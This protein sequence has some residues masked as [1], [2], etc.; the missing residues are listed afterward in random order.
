MRFSC[1]ARRTDS[2]ARH[3]SAW[4]PTSSKLT[5][6]AICWATAASLTNWS[7]P[8]SVCLCN[9]PRP[10]QSGWFHFFSP[11]SSKVRP[12]SCSATK[13]TRSCRP[14]A[15]TKPTSIASCQPPKPSCDAHSTDRG[16]D[17]RSRDLLIV[18]RDISRRTLLTSS[19]GLLAAVNA[20][21]PPT[22]AGRARAALLSDPRTFPSP[23]LAS[24]V[25]ELTVP[26]V[27]RGDR[28]MAIGPSSHRFHRALNP[29]PTW[30]YGGAEYFGPTIEA[31]SDEPLQLTFD[32][33]LGS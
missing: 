25:D 28:T 1:S 4:D 17:T 13:P 32:N 15:S 27:V 30:S 22:T 7:R 10:T 33:T 2:R 31:H 3:S 24:Y 14:R 11:R 23:E 9:L 16:Q 19:L 21:T 5:S 20:I 29:A 6:E 18:S 12:D 8:P 26:P